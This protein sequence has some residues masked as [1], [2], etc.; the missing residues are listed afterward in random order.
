V[1]AAK[2]LAGLDLSEKYRDFSDKE[3]I[4]CHRIPLQIRYLGA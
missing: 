1:I 2:V 3:Y 4:P